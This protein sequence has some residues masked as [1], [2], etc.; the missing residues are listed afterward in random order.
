VIVAASIT[1]LR[2][3]RAAVRRELA[4]VEAEISLLAGVELVQACRRCGCTEFTPCEGGCWWVEA[5]L[6]SACEGL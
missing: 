3:Q 6:C 1:Q 4:A 2:A 5:D